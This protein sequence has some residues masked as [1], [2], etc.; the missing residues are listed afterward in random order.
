V[1]AAHRDAPGERLLGGGHGRA[2]RGA[3]VCGPPATPLRGGWRLST[4][5]WARVPAW[6]RHARASGSW[7]LISTPRTPWSAS[8]AS[9]LRRWLLER[10]PVYSFPLRYIDQQVGSVGLFN[11]APARLDDLDL[12]LAQLLADLTTVSIVGA[13]RY[14]QVG[15]L[16]A[17]AQQRFCGCGGAGA[18]QGAAQCPARSTARPVP[19]PTCGGTSFPV[20]VASARRPSR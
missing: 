11:A 4:S 10:Q 13:H 1:R 8:P 7:S 20:A 12:E 5:S 14:Q 6:R 15:G 9:R 17:D 18:G 2:R 19:L 16:A 3:T